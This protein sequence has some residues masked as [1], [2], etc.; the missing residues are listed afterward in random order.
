MI[1]QRALDDRDM[2]RDH[3]DSHATVAETAARLTAEVEARGMKSF[4][5]IE[6]SGEGRATGLEQGGTKLVV[7]GN[8]R[9]GTPIMQVAPLAGLGLPLKVLVRAD[10]GRRC[11][12]YTPRTDHATWC[13][14]SD[15]LAAGLAGID[16]MAGAA[17]GR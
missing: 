6:H 14:L 1:K 16:A 11:V 9:R 8:P 17:V 15:G 4:T 13:Q 3:I 2:K 10:R 7:S 5:T 12:S